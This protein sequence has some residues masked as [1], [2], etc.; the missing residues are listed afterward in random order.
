MKKRKY[1]KTALKR[2]ESWFGMLFLAPWLI[3]LVV[4]TAYPI[5]YSFWM[6]IC[7]MEFTVNGLESTFIGFKWYTAIFKEDAAFLSAMLDT[8]KFIVFST[9]MILVFSIVLALLLNSITK[10]KTFFRALFFFPV[11]VVSGPIMSRLIS[12]D[13][14]AIIKAEEYGVYEVVAELPEVISVPLLYMFDN[15][16]SFLWYAGVQILIIL[17]GLQKINASL[18]EA[19]DMDGAS[20]WQKFWKITF[21]MMRPMILLSG[22]YTIVQ[23]A[24]LS[25]NSIVKLISKNITRIDSPYSY[26]AALSWL[27][28]IVVLILLLV[29]FLLLK[30]RSKK[31]EKK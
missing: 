23:L 15:V 5:L 16:V 26:S 4:F 10:G 2:R 30:E 27:Y 11:M 13:A 18:Y 9:P 22:I 6:S 28:A 31:N 14:T 21:P 20:G 12:N 29:A 24:N 8:V 17:I 19:A 1:H 3:G 25:T 7:K